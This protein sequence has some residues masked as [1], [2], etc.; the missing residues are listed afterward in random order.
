VPRPIHRFRPAVLAALALV[1]ALAL[2]AAGWAQP[3][4]GRT[5]TPG[6]GTSAT[7]DAQ[8]LARIVGMS[9]EEKVGQLFVTYAYGQSADEIDPRNRSTYGVDTPAQVVQKYRLGGVIYFAWSNNVNN[10][11]QIA[12]LST[13]LQRAA[14]SHHGIPLLIT[15]DQEGGIVARVGPPATQ[16]PGNMALGA[17]RQAEHALRAA[18]ITAEELRTLGI[19]QDYAPVADVNVNPQNPV[20][21]VRSFGEEPDLVSG[22]VRAQV[23]GYQQDDRLAATAK[24][25]PGHGDTSV[26]SHT[27]LP[28]IHHSLAEL[29]KID[30]PPFQKAIERGIA[31]I[32]TAHIVVPALDPSGRP[33]TLS[34]PILTGLLRERL[35]FDGVIVTD[36]LDMAGVRQMVGDERV[37]IEAL[38]AGTDMLLMPPVPDL[39]YHAVLNAVRSGEISEARL[40]RSLYRI[41][42]LKFRLG[43]FT[44]PFAHPERIVQVVGTPQHLATA[45][46]ISDRS[47]TLLKNDA[48]LLPLA[49][50][51]AKPTLV[52]G[53]GVTTTATIGQELTARGLVTEVLS[54]GSNPSDTTIAQAVAAANRSEL[55]V[56]TTSQ[57]WNQ[58][59]NPKQK[60]LVNALFQTG[61]PLIAVAVREPYDIAYFTAAPTY[62][63][64]YGFNPVSLRALVRVL[65]GEVNPSG[66]L[67]VTIPAA[68][69]PGR[70]LF[71]YG[72]G[73]SYDR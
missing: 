6:V 9:L 55:V 23:A 37:P 24:H 36:A 67:P 20:I 34:R 5:P 44:D 43:L 33:A 57:A 54:T 10:P 52:T 8:V 26:D 29:D 35:G 51:S 64:T 12:G 69:D 14:L 2:P 72:F 13:G 68:D 40:N 22:L 41:L 11:P 17:A 30:L 48:G 21:G 71:P 59:L 63:T 32:M 58:V 15:T 62:L 39:Q 16:F 45:D 19:N 47:V 18:L 28:V 53:F 38:K 60:D 7:L 56:V 73:L 61:R 31:S 65:F 27:G 49:P 1:V 46:R 42:R 25:F 4:A 70:I 66:K 3:T 50:D